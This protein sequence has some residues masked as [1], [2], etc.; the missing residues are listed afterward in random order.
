MVDV[1]FIDRLAEYGVLSQSDANQIKT[2]A[3]SG[4]ADAESLLAA[5]NVPPKEILRAKSETYGV[6]AYELE[7]RK[8]PFDVLKYIPEE[9]AQHYRF[10]PLDVKDGVLEVGVLDPANIEAREALKFITSKTNVPFKIY[11]ISLKDLNEILEEYKSLGGEVTKVL[12]EFEIALQEEKPEV[13]AKEMMK[14]GGFVEEA[15]VT[16]MVAVII[17]HATEGRASDIH[18]EPAKDKIRV[19]FRVDGILYTSLLLPLNMREAIVSRLKIMTNMKLDEKRKP[20][21]GRF[22]AKVEGREIDFRVSTLPTA[23]G[24]KVAIRILDPESA[25]LDLTKLGL[26][27]RNFSVIEH[28]LKEPYGLILLTGP[29]GSGKTT[30]LY[31]MLKTINNEKY[32]IISLEDPIEY[33][34]AGVNQSQV[35]PEIGYDF[36]SGLRSILRQDPDIILV[37]EIRDKETAG[38]AIH[39]ALTGHLVLSTLHTNNAVGAIPRLVDMG[40][41]RYLIAPT[42]V[43]VIAQRLTQTLCPDSRRPMKIAGNLKEKIEDELKD[44]PEPTK[45]TIKM[46]KEIYEAQPS[47]MCPKGTRGRIGVFEVLAASKELEKVILTEPST[48]NLEREARRQGMITMRE[49]GVLKVLKGQIGIEQLAQL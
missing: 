40:I 38:L 22:S 8:V 29:T 42:L 23:F 30:T 26:E 36:S 45:S 47:A 16:K 12:S 14:E 28:A 41:D 46:P 33:N 34:I 31:A 1:S 35:R 48:E 15:P 43:A 25:T 6:P 5:K 20:Q 11:A 10:A 2:D 24:E 7:G 19:R 4:R 21:D 49:D 27:G 32:N 13:S 39:A 17:K 3:A 37:G 44:V 18:I 9:S